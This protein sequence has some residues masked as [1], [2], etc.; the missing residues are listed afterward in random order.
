MNFGEHIE[1]TAN[2]LIP[3]TSEEVLQCKPG[4]DSSLILSK[5]LSYALFVVITYGVSVVNDLS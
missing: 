5:W 2:I 3:H 1:T 4:S